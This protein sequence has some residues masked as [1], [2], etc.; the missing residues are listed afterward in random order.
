MIP[1]VDSICDPDYIN[2][3]LLTFLHAREGK[4][5]SSSEE[6]INTFAYAATYEDL[7]KKIRVCRSVEELEKIRLVFMFVM[8]I[9]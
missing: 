7:I 1:F 4:G 5:T 3:T 6:S 2:R 8:A 9:W